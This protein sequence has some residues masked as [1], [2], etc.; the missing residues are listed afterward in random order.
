MRLIDADAYAEEM[1]KKQKVLK[2][3]MDK[4]KSEEKRE[5]WN[6][7]YMTFVEANLT[8]DNMQKIDAVPVVRCM[9]CIYRDE[10]HYCPQIDN[11]AEDCFYC[12][13]GER[14]EE[15]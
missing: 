4:E 14:K 7:V 1:R 6:G 3:I 13:D 2:E 9:D 8:I 11:Y 15:E 5:Y 10:E 12:A